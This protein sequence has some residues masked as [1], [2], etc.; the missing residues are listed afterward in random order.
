LVISRLD[1][2]YYIIVEVSDSGKH[3]SLL[4]YGKN[5]GDEKFYCTGTG[6][7]FINVLRV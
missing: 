6:A 7:N 3:S 4:Q 5:Y 2:K 1:C